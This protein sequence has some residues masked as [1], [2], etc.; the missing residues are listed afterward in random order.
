[1]AQAPADRVTD[2]MGRILTAYAIA[3]ATATLQPALAADHLA[4][5][6]ERGTSAVST[7]A[8]AGAERAGAGSPP[9]AAAAGAGDKTFRRLA[10][11]RATPSGS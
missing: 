6:R 11:P 9:A 7:V 5:A 4:A 10:V 2:G 1:M 3:A 8:T